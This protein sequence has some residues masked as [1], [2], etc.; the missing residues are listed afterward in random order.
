M[1]GM[2]SD[3]TKVTQSG[4]GAASDSSSLRCWFCAVFTALSN[5][6]FC[7]ERENDFSIDQFW[8]SL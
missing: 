4:V 1:S 8:G 7:N 3:T 2:G 5:E 6:L